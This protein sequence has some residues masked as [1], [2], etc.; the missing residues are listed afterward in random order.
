MM[1]AIAVTITANSCKTGFSKGTYISSLE[2]F[3]NAVERDYQGFDETDWQRADQKMTAFSDKYGSY[4][5]QFTTDE[6]R[7]VSKLMTKYQA[8]RVK[9]KVSGVVK[10]IGDIIDQGVGAFDGL[11]EGIDIK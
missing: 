4:V 7:K 8:I 2:S 3:V 6:K 5:D 9:A 11:L 1:F 10:G